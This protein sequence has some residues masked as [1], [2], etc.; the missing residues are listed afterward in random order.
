MIAVREISR[1][2]LPTFNHCVNYILAL[3][4]LDTVTSA[5]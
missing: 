4:N 1:I 3:I 2:Y 5:S